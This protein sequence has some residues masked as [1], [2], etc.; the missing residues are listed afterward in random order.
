VLLDIHCG[1]VL[2]S[3]VDA[4]LFDKDGTL[5]N[6]EAYLLALGRARSLWLEMD[7]PG[8]SSMLYQAWGIT[9]DA[10]QAD[11]LL[12]VR[13]RHENAIAAETCLVDYGLDQRDAERIVQEA[14][15]K[16]DQTMPDKAMATPLLEGSV[17]VLKNL[18]AAGIRLGILS[19]DSTA[20]V[21]AFVQ[22]YNL[23]PYIQVCLGTDGVLKKPDPALFEWACQRLSVS[24][25]RTLM[26]GDS[27]ADM[28]MAR[29]AR[30]L[31][32]IGVTWGWTHPCLPS[33]ADTIVERLDQICVA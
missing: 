4:V 19:S 5:A 7:Y 18:S 12:A 1:D 32:G 10:V 24:P 14:F 9:A 27:A 2:F 15:R 21:V 11:G 3:A 6:S 29:A 23:H 8:I 16:A 22:Q 20:N 26:V 25:Q 13:T 31:G 33:D 28:V 30:A 17:S